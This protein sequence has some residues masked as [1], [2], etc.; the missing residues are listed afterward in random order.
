MIEHANGVARL[1]WLQSCTAGSGCFGRQPNYGYDSQ[2]LGMLCCS[3]CSTWVLLGDMGVSEHSGT[4][5]LSILIG[6]SIIN[7]SILG[8]L[9]SLER[10]I[11]CHQLILHPPVLQARLGRS[12]ASTIQIVVFLDVRYKNQCT[13]TCNNMQQQTNKKNVS[14]KNKQIIHQ[15]TK[16]LW[17][18]YISKGTPFKQNKHYTPEN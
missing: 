8:C 18:G 2:W 16:F 17:T 3:T 6:F 5:K 12:Q 15:R 11:W 14:Q 9:Y 7:P 10:P 13:T 4:P 1:L